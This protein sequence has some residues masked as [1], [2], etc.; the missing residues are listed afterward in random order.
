VIARRFDIPRS[1]G[2][3]L[4]VF[5]HPAQ[6]LPPTSSSRALPHFL[7]ARF[8]YYAYGFGST[9]SSNTEAAQQAYLFFQMLTL[10][11]SMSCAAISHALL[12]YIYHRP[13]AA[14]ADSFADSV[15]SN[16]R[17]VFRLVL[18]SHITCDPPCPPSPSPPAFFSLTPRAA[19]AAPSS[20]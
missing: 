3:Q 20:S 5:G 1:F 2:K 10:A 14:F 6:P 17:L 9:A 15:I 12:F 11:L 8:R 13:S 7:T 19:T 16:V 4:G 18:F